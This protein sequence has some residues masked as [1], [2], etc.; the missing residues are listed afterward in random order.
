MTIV[1]AE[2]TINKVEQICD[3]ATDECISDVIEYTTV[4]IA[5]EKPKI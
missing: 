5:K 1:N 4:E 3:A 2:D